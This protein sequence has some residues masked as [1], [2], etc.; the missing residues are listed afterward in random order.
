[1]SPNIVVALIT[2]SASVIIAAAT[3]FL[4]KRSER[5]AQLRQRK[6]E[7]YYDLLRAFAA[8]HDAT[9]DVVKAR[10]QLANAINLVV[11]VAPQ[12]VITSVMA[13]Y[14]EMLIWPP[15]PDEQRRLLLDLILKLRK[16]L[17]LPFED[18]AST[19]DFEIVSVDKRVDS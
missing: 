5:A 13:I 4:T 12:Y 10:Q 14:H 17:E 8:F 9:S 6:E 3:F 11:L 15:R 18:D 2:A 1:M 16:S 19:F 7:Q